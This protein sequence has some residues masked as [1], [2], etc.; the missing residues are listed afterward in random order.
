AGEWRCKRQPLVSVRDQNCDGPVSSRALQVRVVVSPAAETEAAD[1][2]D[3]IQQLRKLRRTRWKEFAVLYR[4]HRHRDR[5]AQELAER[6]IPYAVSGLDVLE[7]TPVRDLLAVLRAAAG[8]DH[9]SGLLRGASRALLHTNPDALRAAFVEAGRDCKAAEV[10]KSV[11]GGAP[12]IEAVEQA[13]SEIARRP[14]KVVEILSLITN[15]FKLD[16]SEPSLKTF[17][18]FAAQWQQ[19]PITERGDLAELL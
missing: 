2:A 18:E 7:T 17:C 6:D 13:R 5:L 8:R 12:V 9:A 1:I 16:V 14:M 15:R 3:S 4:S 10:I 11:A 19:K